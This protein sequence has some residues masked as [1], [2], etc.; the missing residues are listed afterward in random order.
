MT[1]GD[2]WLAASGAMSKPNGDRY[3]GIRIFD[4][5]STFIRE[6]EVPFEDPAITN[7][8]EILGLVGAADLVGIHLSSIGGTSTLKVYGT[9]DGLERWTRSF[10]GQD[11]H[12]AASASRI[13]AGRYQETVES[14][15]QDGLVE[16]LSSVDGSLETTLYSQP[17]LGASQFGKLMACS[18]DHLAVFDLASGASKV[19]SFQVPDW[20]TPT[21]HV[22]PGI[23]S[24]SDEF[25]QLISGNRLLF[26]EN[27]SSFGALDLM[28]GTV[29]SDVIQISNVVA[30]SGTSDR[31]VFC[32]TRRTVHHAG[33]ET[34][35]PGPPVTV[36]VDPSD[37]SSSDPK[38]AA[39]GETA[40][41][42]MWDYGRGGFRSGGVFFVD[43][44]P[45][46]P[47]VSLHMSSAREMDGLVTGTLELEGPVD[48]PVQITLSTE[49]GT[50]EDGA[51]FVGFVNRTIVIPAGEQ[52]QSFEIPLI[53]DTMVEPP[54]SFR[55]VIDQVVGAVPTED[56]DGAV[57]IGSGLTRM[58]RG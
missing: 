16:V 2:G 37:P 34:F 57:V 3:I 4:E 14:I 1:A 17:L 33:P 58:A 42:G 12:F 21:T 5:S 25:T 55:V 49:S 28:T 39:S 8:N 10:T 54:E 23:W 48:S 53:R 29:T 45:E 30:I 19:T 36:W 15:P 38:V 35:A 40:I 20:N 27:G 43:L 52:R 47:L 22:L 46:L 32:D 41:L 26:N 44:N 18:G 9:A 56:S 24:Q 11:I 6:I 7:A 31:L 13:Y 51:D 50:A